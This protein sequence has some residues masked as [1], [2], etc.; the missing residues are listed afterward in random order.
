M[1]DPLTL[2]FIFSGPVIK[3]YPFKIELEALVFLLAQISGSPFKQA[4]ITVFT[5]SKSLVQKFC[6]LRAGSTFSVLGS[7][8]SNFKLLHIDK[9]L[10]LEAHR[11]E[12]EGLQ[13]SKIIHSW[14]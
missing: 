4:H 11:L 3:D 8:I 5:Y 9:S 6:F 1:S 12:K 14:L 10:N 13:R 2:A 7:D